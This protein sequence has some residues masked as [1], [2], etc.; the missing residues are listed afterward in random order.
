MR[1]WFL[2][3]AIFI[4]ILGLFPPERAFS[5]GEERIRNVEVSIEKGEI[6][7]SAELVHGFTPQV[8]VDLQNGIPKDFYF[9][10]LLKKEQ[11]GW[12]DE[13]ILSRTI[14]Y[15]IKFDNLK[16]QYLLTR[17]DGSLE[18]EILSESFPAAEALI[19][20]IN[21][22]R[23][24][25]LAL[26]NPKRTYYVSVK[27]QMRASQLPLYL[28]YFLFFIP[29]LEIDTPWADSRPFTRRSFQ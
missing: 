10:F 20:K 22:V 18:E 5:A 28:D 1:R 12:F 29:F 27:A 9:Y 25:P 14:R 16:K 17:R 4:G 11:T 8:I 2:H 23:I 15:S 3:G 21:H 19:S 13:E 26:L 6:T 24:A 7:V